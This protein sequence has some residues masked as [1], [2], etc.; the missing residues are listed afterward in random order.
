MELGGPII[1]E[2]A[3]GAEIR[4]WPEGQ[5]PP[6]KHESWPT[7]KPRDPA[8]PPS[9]RSDSY[10]SS[11]IETETDD[12]AS[13]ENGDV[14]LK[15]PLTMDSS[16]EKGQDNRFLHQLDARLLA[17]AQRPRQASMAESDG[18]NGFGKIDDDVDDGGLRLKLKKSMNFG[19]AFGSKICGKI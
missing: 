5:A 10:F 9:E 8:M 1:S 12:E 3:S 11:A 2:P 6:I 14:E 7:S 15:G 13:Q 17:E 4:K 16:I 19:S 18:K